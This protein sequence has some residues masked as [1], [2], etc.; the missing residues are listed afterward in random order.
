MA[1]P[2]RHVQNVEEF[3]IHKQ[4]FVAID[5]LF[6]AALGALVFKAFDALKTEGVAALGEDL[7]DAGV[8]VELLVAGIALQ[9]R[10]HF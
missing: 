4:S 9:E 8:L 10:F 1:F 6:L 3:L 7:G 2:L 5:P